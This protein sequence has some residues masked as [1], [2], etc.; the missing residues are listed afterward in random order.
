MIFD[1]TLYASLSIF[2]FGLCYRLS[3]WFRTT[4]GLSPAG[5]SSSARFAAAAR[6][7]LGAV[8]STKILALLKIFLLDILLQFRILRDKKDPLVWSM[9][10][11]IYG[12]FTL[13]LLLHALDRFITA[14]LFGEYSSTLNPFLFLRNFLGLA[15]LVGLILAVIRRI[16]L[17]RS[18]LRNRP[19]DILAIAILAV[20]AISGFLL[21]GAKMSSFSSYG[22]MVEGYAVFQSQEEAKALEAF[23]VKEF[24]VASPNDFRNVSKETLE[25]GRRLSERSCAG[26]HSNPRWAFLSYG[27]A[28]LTRPV[29]LSL[30]RVGYP[31]LLWYLH[32][33]SCFFGL[34][35]LPFSKF[36]H[37]IATPVSLLVNAVIEEGR[38]NPAN[39]ATKLSIELDGC[40]HG[41]ACHD[42]CPLQKK[43][44]EALQLASKEDPFYDYF[45][46]NLHLAK[47]TG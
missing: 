45:Q 15:V 31:R 29:A 42:G 41:G 8:A 39:I 43:R 9:H 46:K 21:E 16:Q 12:G 3:S 14:R 2:L 34:A 23:W 38:S 10:L 30:D 44:L 24:G 17:R 25:Q 33:L 6:G 1:L 18:G 40:K 7:I 22:E 27:A 35:Y 47:R 26:C 28:E 32:F 19:M 13:L 5:I 20:I 4:V 11:C 36:L 37:I